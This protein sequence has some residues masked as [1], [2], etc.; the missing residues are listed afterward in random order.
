M[1]KLERT[2]E[3]FFSVQPDVSA[4]KAEVPGQQGLHAEFRPVSQQAANRAAAGIVRASS[5]LVIV[6]KALRR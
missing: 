1:D 2:G 5:S 4:I 6:T 3:M